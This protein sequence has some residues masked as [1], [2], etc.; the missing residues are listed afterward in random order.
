MD[1]REEDDVTVA[2][3]EGISS[4][5]SSLASETEA[6]EAGSYAPL[7]GYPSPVSETFREMRCASGS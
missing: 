4:T 1:E 5:G 7:K 6:R 3:G 2:A